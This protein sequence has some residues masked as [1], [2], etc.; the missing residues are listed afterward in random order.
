MMAKTDRPDLTQI[1]RELEALGSPRNVEGM[2][3]FGI[4]SK[5]AFG[6]PTPAIRKLGRRLGRNHDMALRLWGTG[7]L[8]ARALATLVDD[9]RKVS[10]RQ[11]EEWVKDF[12]NWATC[13]GCC[14][15]LFDKTPFAYTKAM[16]WSEREEEFVKRAA[17]TLMATLT[18]HDKK[19]VDDRFL[20]FLP[21]I[22]REAHDG[23]NYV[24]KSVNWALRQI[25][26]RSQSLNIAAVKVAKRLEEGDSPAERW[27]AADALR[28]LLSPAVMRRLE[29]R[30]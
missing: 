8:D 14:G 2:A 3:R 20:A 24:K 23:R 10:A 6:A 9:P 25:G 5:N 17:F 18:V 16:E 29:S 28:E 12:D 22:A 13:D 21:V 19:A 7:N 27:V 11:M 1:M 30:R 4:T 26:K 15:N